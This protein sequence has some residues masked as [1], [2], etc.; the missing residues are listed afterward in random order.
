MKSTWATDPKSRP[1]AD[2][3]EYTKE[4]KVAEELIRDACSKSMPQDYRFTVEARGTAWDVYKIEIKGRPG[5]VA[6]RLIG[7][8][9]EIGYCDL[10]L[11][12][13]SDDIIQ[14]LNN[15]DN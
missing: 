5:L 9:L 4:E 10:A 8:E 2:T 15:Q 12:V 6:F 14:V 1:V 3:R 7:P 11:D 13:T